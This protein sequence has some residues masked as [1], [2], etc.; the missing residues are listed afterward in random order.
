MSLKNSILALSLLATVPAYAGSFTQTNLVSDGAIPAANT[1]PNLK[2]PWG[3]SFAPG[4]A[5]WDSD[6]D[7]GLTTLYDS[8]GTV[9]PLV[10]TIPPAARSKATGTPTGQVFNPSSTDFAVKKGKKSGVAAFL[11]AT[12][13]GTISGWSPAVS[14][15]AAILAVDQSKTGAVFDGLAY[16]TDSTGNNFLL[17]ADLH[18][19]VVDVFDK[20]FNL[21]SSFRDTTLE[22]VYAPFNV[23]VLNGNIYVAYGWINAA[24]NNVIPHPGWGVVEQVSETGTVMHKVIG[25]KLN[26]PWGLAIAP[27]GFGTFGGD[28]LV[29]NFGDGRITAF[30][31][32]LKSKG[33]IKI[34]KKPLVIDGLWALIVGNGGSG[35]SASDVY[36]TAGPNGEADGLMG[37]LSYAP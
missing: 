30:N 4:G 2:N 9:E 1:D 27:T 26:A 18:G 21:V 15:T 14:E 16:Y 19:G 17:A 36:F 6:N 37:S 31:A 5:F 12:E 13:D 22:S 8:S 20:G 32:L 34:G 35:G 23:A 28:L 24:G 29:G 11:F 25:G 33:Q 3:V 7:T 10:V